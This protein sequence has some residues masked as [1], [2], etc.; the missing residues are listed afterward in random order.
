MSPRAEKMAR[1]GKQQP[2]DP[3]MRRP[4]Q[5]HWKANDEN[6]DFFSKL[7]S[8]AEKPQKNEGGL[9]PEERFSSRCVPVAGGPAK[10]F[11]HGSPSMD[12]APSKPR[13]LRLGWE[14]TNVRPPLRV[15]L[16]VTGCHA[17]TPSTAIRSRRY[18][19][20]RSHNAGSWTTATGVPTDRSSSVGWQSSGFAT[21]PRLTGLRWI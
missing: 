10:F 4:N 17:A 13:L 14:G 12:C 3:F 20:P 5:R 11:T 16:P 21:S 2:G 8:R 7:F 18:P 1:R 9:T 15:P 6:S 19:S